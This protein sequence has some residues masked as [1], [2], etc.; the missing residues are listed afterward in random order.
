MSLRLTFIEIDLKV[1]DLK[2]D[3]KNLKLVNLTEDW[4]QQGHTHWR[5]GW[6]S[7]LLLENS[8]G[9]SLNNSTTR[10]NLVRRFNRLG[11]QTRVDCTNTRGGLYAVKVVEVLPWLTP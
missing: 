5:L 9:R 11:N 8:V 1:T 10:M 4:S 2:V 6:I 7:W 3:L